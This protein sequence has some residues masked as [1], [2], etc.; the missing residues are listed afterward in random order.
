MLKFKTI[1]DLMEKIEEL[2]VLYSC[3]SQDFLDLIDDDLWTID[4]SSIPSYTIIDDI[5]HVTFES[6][7]SLKSKYIQRF[8]EDF[9]LTLTDTVILEDNKYYKYY[10][11]CQE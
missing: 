7:V 2:Q 1:L 10:F 11:K 6:P 9:G 3:L 5:I 8:E 4:L